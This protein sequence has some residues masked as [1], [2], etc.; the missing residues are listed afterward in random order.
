VPAVPVLLAEERI[1]LMT[2]SWIGAAG[3]RRW[4]A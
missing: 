1:A 4:S 2:V 3:R